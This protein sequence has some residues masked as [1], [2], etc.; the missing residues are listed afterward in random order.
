[1]PF[2]KYTHL[3]YHRT[4]EYIEVKL[5][6]NNDTIDSQTFEIRTDNGQ[7]KLFEYIVE[8]LGLNFKKFQKEMETEYY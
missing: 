8:K 2:K 5:K 1:M 3:D 4:G 6:N 7:R